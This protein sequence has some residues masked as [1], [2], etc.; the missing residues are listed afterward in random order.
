L[1]T[2]ARAAVE[3]NDDEWR[4]REGEAAMMESAKAGEREPIEARCKSWP[5]RQVAGPDEP[6]AE[7]GAAKAPAAEAPT[8]HRTAKATT[9]ARAAEA[10]TY[11]RT[12]KATADA[13]AAEAPAVEAAAVEAAAVETPAAAAHPGIRCR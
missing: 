1:P 7:T 9:D 2:P 10:S 11:H 12:A 4:R 3:T 8:H 13:P 5:E 6:T